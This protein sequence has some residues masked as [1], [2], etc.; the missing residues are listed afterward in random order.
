MLGLLQIDSFQGVER[1]RSTMIQSWKFSIGG[2]PGMK[3]KAG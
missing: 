2:Y 1:P 3:I